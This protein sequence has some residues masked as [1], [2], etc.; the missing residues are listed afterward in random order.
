MI[1]SHARLPVPT[2]P[3]DSVIMCNLE[4][5]QA[6]ETA[7]LSAYKYNI[8]S[9]KIRV[10]YFC[11]VQSEEIEFSKVGRH[12]LHIPPAALDASTLYSLHHM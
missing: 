6:L 4:Q 11:V 9:V 2:R 5:Y 3:R 10:D 1:L 8:L 12:D 7:W